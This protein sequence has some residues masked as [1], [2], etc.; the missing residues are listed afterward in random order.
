MLRPGEGSVLRR[1]DLRQL[2]AARRNERSFLSSLHHRPRHLD[3]L[4]D[5]RRLPGHG[6]ASSP[7]SR[8]RT[9]AGTPSSRTPSPARSTPPK[10]RSSMPTSPPA[11]SPGAGMAAPRHRRGLAARQGHRRRR[12]ARRGPHRARRQEGPHRQG[13]AGGAAEGLQRRLDLQAHLDAAAV[14]PSTRSSR[15]P[16]P[17]RTSKARKSRSPPPSTCSEEPKP[18]PLLPP[19][20]AASSTTTRPTC[21]RRPMRRPKPD[22]AKASPFETLLKDDTADSGRFIPPMAKG[23]HDW[24]S[25]PLPPACSRRSEQQLPRRPASISRRAANR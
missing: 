8:D 2:P 3:R 1:V 10:C 13:R 11:R 14:R 23:D 5:R 9:R 15:W 22:Y 25:S 17:S 20:L 7:A 4:S 19:V 18:D 21:W 6:R 16:S 12:D 24:M